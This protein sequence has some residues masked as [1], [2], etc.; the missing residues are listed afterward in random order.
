MKRW[1]T[2]KGTEIYKILGGSAGAYALVAGGKLL[3][4]D[5]GTGNRWPALRKHIEVLRKEKG[6]PTA[7][8]LTHTHFD[9]CTNAGKIKERY[10]IPVLV[11]RN[12]A[13][14]LLQGRSPLPVGSN[15]L[16]RFLT[17]A[18]SGKL[19]SAFPY[20]SVAADLVAEGNRTLEDLGFPGVRLLPTPGHSSGSQ[21][22]IVDDEIAIVGDALFAILPRSAYPIFAEDPEQ[23]LDSWKALLETGCRLYLPGHGRQGSRKRLEGN[24]ARRRKRHGTR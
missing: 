2:C 7:L 9:H 23:L 19:K 14:N 20:D 8:V 4:V 13:D 10:D 22:L 3:L 5:T 18:L 21:S 12:E 15:P 1:I 24:Y 17:D 16:L 6:D 11:H